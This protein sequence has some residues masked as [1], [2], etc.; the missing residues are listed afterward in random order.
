MPARLQSVVKRLLCALRMWLARCGA[1][2]VLLLRWVALSIGV[3]AAL[4]VLQACRLLS[5]VNEW[6]LRVL[7]GDPFYL[8]AA[9]AQVAL[10]SPAVIFGA[11]VCL[12]LYLSAVL[13]RMPSMGQRSHLCLLAAVAVALPGV[14]CVLWHGVLYVAQPL[15]CVLLLW[16]AVVPCAMIRRCFLS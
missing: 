3:L 10:F 4:V 1:A 8:P 9:D 2:D 7:V 11:C 15:V 13:L 6:Q 12:T 16:L 14:M 5:P